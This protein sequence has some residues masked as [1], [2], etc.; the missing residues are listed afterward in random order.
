MASR[1]RPTR[2]I[3]DPVVRT[4]AVQNSILPRDER[5]A[6]AL[7]IQARTELPVYCCGVA[8]PANVPIDYPPAWFTRGQLAELQAHPDLDVLVIPQAA[9]A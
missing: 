4:G 6:P 7:R 1:P 8:H 5:P 2:A 9:A 3:L